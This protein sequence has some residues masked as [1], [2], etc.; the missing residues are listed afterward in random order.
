MNYIDAMRPTLLIRLYRG[1]VDHFHVRFNEWV[2]LVPSFGLWLI[3]S[4]NPELFSRSPSFTAMAAWFG[5]STWSLIFGLAMVC[6]LAALAVNGTFQGFEFSPHI[7]AAASV[8]GILIWSQVG[9]G[10][11]LSYL[12]GGGL[13]T[14]VMMYTLPV[15]L[16]LQNAWRSFMD[17]GKQFPKDR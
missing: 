5:E 17:V 6:R 15:I 10:F 1:V 3:L 4:Y 9:L 7:R 13:P 8:V 14:P 16:E 11:L 12:H 2:M